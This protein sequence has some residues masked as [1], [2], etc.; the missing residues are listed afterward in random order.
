MYSLT[1]PAAGAGGAG[2]GRS[3]QLCRARH[4]APRAPVWCALRAARL[5]E[6][7][8]MGNTLHHWVPSVILLLSTLLSSTGVATGRGEE[9]YISIIVRRVS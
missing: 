5:V 9:K 6:V 2:Q 3:E 1:A 8:R 4:R 7:R